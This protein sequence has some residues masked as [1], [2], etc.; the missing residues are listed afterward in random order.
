MMFGRPSPPSSDATN[1]SKSVGGVAKPRLKVTQECHQKRED[2]K[3]RHGA[4][5]IKHGVPHTYIPRANAKSR[6]ERKLRVTQ[7]I[8]ELRKA[9]LVAGLYESLKNMRVRPVAHKQNRAGKECS[10]SRDAAKRKCQ[11][12]WPKQSG[13]Y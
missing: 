4:P 2:A 5:K 7:E 8:R 10:H 11:T 3:R 13:F 9:S 12:A 6:A 1:G